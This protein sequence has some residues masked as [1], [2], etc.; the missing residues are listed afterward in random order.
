MSQNIPPVSVSP[1]VLD[2]PRR[3]GQLPPVS[4]LA[5]GCWRLTGTDDDT[6]SA[7]NTAVDLGINLIDTADVYGLDWGGT[8]FGSCEE[9]LG[10]LFARQPGLREKVVLATKGG[11]IPGQPYDSSRDYLIAAC[12]ASLRRLNTDHVDLYQIH[13]PDMFTHPDE[14]FA[15]FS[16]LRGRGL[17]GE[18]GASNYTVSGTQLLEARLSFNLATVQPEFSVARLDPMRDGTLDHC[19]KKSLVPLAWS[20]LAGGR[21]ATGEGLRPGLVAVLD[22]LAAREGVT[23]TAIAVAFVLAHP[24]RPVAILGTQN[25]A[26]LAELARATT[27]TLTKPDLYRIVEASDGV[28]L[29]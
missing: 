1:V 3:I 9:S 2:A 5:F 21:V 16:S 6:A 28:P 27:V 7:V 4:P 26:R 29:P 22:E 17:V 14:I 8:A 10:R 23:R 24:S 15:A 20:P 11:I 19:M 18:V 13:R 12:E 25:P